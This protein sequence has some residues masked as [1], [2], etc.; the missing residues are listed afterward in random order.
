M[1]GMEFYVDPSRCIG[2]QACLKACE[3]CE[4]HR[5]VSMI[6]FDFMDRARD[7]R[8]CRVRLLALRRSHLRPGLPRRRDQEIRG[9]HGRLVAQAALHR[10]LQLRAGL[11]L[12]DSEAGSRVRAD[13]E[14]RHVLRPHVGGQA[15]DVRHR[16]PQPGAGLRHA[17]EHRRDRREKPV[18][19][20]WF[21]NQKI[22]TKVY[23][24]A[25]AG[26][27]AIA[28]DVADYTW[29]GEHE[30]VPQAF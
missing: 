16:L 20:F 8:H 22:T 28:I 1:F 4:T 12:R 2:C 7:H 23:M 17:G 18:N 6:N 11:P 27:D 30:A 10:L 9:R 25:P 29:E 15:P 19:T 14:V 26:T 24:M 5:G 13:D 21:G 3:E